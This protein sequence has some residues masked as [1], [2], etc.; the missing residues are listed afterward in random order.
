MLSA[1]PCLLARA[2]GSILLRSGGLHDLWPPQQ[3][4]FLQGQLGYEFIKLSEERRKAFQQ[5]G[6]VMPIADPR[7]TYP[8]MHYFLQT[9]GICISGDMNQTPLEYRGTY[10]QSSESVNRQQKVALN[11]LPIA[12]EAGC[13]RSLVLF[14]DNI[15][16]IPRKCRFA[17]EKNAKR[18][19]TGGMSTL[20]G[21]CECSYVHTW[22]IQY[23]EKLQDHAHASV[24]ACHKRR[25]GIHG[26]GKWHPNSTRDNPMPAYDKSLKSLYLQFGTIPRCDIDT[27]V[28]DERLEINNLPLF[29][30]QLFSLTTCK[31]MLLND[32]KVDIE[33]RTMQ[34]A[35]T[36]ARDTTYA[37]Q[38][39]WINLRAC[40]DTAR[41]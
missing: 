21:G 17:E 6:E 28:P 24:E 16:G 26:V 3:L 1:M 40:T 39:A 5:F 27:Y 7:R 14:N 4:P 41:L 23:C 37:A 13:M 15:F 30:P 25:L 8:S 20:R 31:Q 18:R 29:V 9:Q 2:I 22:S 11:S 12:D 36:V 32:E 33:K 35:V 38:Q 19:C 10:A 34:N